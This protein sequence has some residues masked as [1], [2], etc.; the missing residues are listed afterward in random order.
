MQG[1]GPEQEPGA[2][3]P[4]LPELGSLEV[5]EGSLFS[6]AHSPCNQVQELLFLKI[7]IDLKSFVP[8]YL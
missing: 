7:L 8:L 5:L 4:P 2:Q 1:K 3:L 6:C